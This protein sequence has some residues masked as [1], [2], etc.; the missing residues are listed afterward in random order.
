MWMNSA[1]RLTVFSFSQTHPAKEHSKRLNFWPDRD[2]S[3]SISLTI[4]RAD[5]DNYIK[6][7]EDGEQVMDLQMRFFDEENSDERVPELQSATSPPKVRPEH[8]L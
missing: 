1:V 3:M 4:A 6:H 2:S 5:L 8:F 7:S